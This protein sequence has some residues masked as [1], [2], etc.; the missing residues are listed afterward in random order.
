M[1]VLMIAGNVG[2]D[3]ELRQANGKDVLNF[4]V[5]VDNG[6]DASGEKRA[7]TWFDCAIWGDRASKL[8]PH[9]K[10]GTKMTIT[11]RPTARAH[12]GKAYL[13]LTVNDF[14]FQ[15]S[16]QQAEGGQRRETRRED[17]Y[18]QG[19]SSGGQSRSS[20]PKSSYDLNDDIPF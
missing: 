12:D 11:G 10:K 17:D 9:I 1:Q 2:K 4:S 6:K 16:A 14:T 7:P 5:A 15:G 18:S 3:S 8:E 13:G 20:G 19:F